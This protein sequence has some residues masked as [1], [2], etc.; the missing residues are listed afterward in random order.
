MQSSEIATK[1]DFDHIRYAQ[2]WEDAD[3]LTQALGDCAGGTLVSIC[4]AG[5]NA[6]AMLT[7]D[8]Q[9]VVVVDLSPAQ[10]ACLNLRIGAFRHL[11][12]PE[13]LELMGARPSTLRAELLNRSLQG[14]DQDTCDFW[15]SLE[16]D[17]VQFGAGGLGKFERYFRIFRT[18]L[19]P[20]VHRQKTIDDIF[21]SKPKAER[22]TF[23]ETRFN[24][25]RWRLLLNFFFSRFVMGRMGRD[26]AFFDHVDGSPAQHVARRIRHAAV[27]CD[28]AENPYLHWIMK[29]THGDALPMT[30]R[31]ANFDLIKSRLD[32][33]EI[34]PGSLEAFVSTGEKAD[35]FN[36]SDIFEYMSPDIFAQVYGSILQASAPGARLVYWNMMAPRRV[37]PAIMDRV[38]TLSELEDRLKVQDKAFFYSDFVVEQVKD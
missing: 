12:H 28:P 9:K 32:R 14:L 18:R 24:T 16:S 21:V 15:Q 25:W 36:L 8:P 13:F 3:V 11:T 38:T 37:P 10:I 20:L 26:K 22:Q 6:L 7:L 31:A 29:G 33:L 23:L 19:L 27:D 4:S 5:D 34:R 1:A 2:L 30:W 35:G 17:V